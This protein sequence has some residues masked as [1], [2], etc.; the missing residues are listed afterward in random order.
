MYRFT[1]LLCVL[2]AAQAMAAPAP[3]KPA[4][5]NTAAGE[6]KKL[7]GSW[8]VVSRSI[9]GHDRPPQGGDMTVVIRG[10]RLQFLVNGDVRTEWAITLDVKKT[11]KLLDRERVAVAGRGEKKGPKGSALLFLGIYQ[12]EKDTLKINSR[13]AVGSQERPTEFRPGQG[14]TL[15]VLE[16]KK[17]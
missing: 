2:A 13:T 14:L 16:R 15:Y 8:T 12:L 9:N 10:D 1:S 17:P 11:P 7:Q 6:L 3:L 5:Q 4:Q